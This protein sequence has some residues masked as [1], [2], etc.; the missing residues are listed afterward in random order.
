MG[1][2]TGLERITPVIDAVQSQIKLKAS[3][4]HPFMEVLKEELPDLHESLNEYYGECYQ[5]FKKHRIT[6]MIMYNKT[7][8]FFYSDYCYVYLVTPWIEYRPIGPYLYTMHLKCLR[9]CR[10]NQL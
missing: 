3:L 5:N 2:M 6:Y 4:F 9:V 7:T 1:L 8:C 10:V